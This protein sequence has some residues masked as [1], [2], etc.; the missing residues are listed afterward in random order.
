MAKV[1]DIIKISDRYNLLYTE[2]LDRM[3]ET[4]MERYNKADYEEAEL[5]KL[6]V[7]LNRVELDSSPK[8]IKNTFNICI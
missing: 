6:H 2:V 4:F 3:M 7:K 8:D 5:S 1:V